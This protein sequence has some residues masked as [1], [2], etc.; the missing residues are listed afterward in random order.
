MYVNTNIDMCPAIVPR[1]LEKAAYVRAKGG[2]YPTKL[3][4]TRCDGSCTMVGKEQE[5]NPS[6]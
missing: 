5:R 6:L 3:T 1:K 2:T 4:R